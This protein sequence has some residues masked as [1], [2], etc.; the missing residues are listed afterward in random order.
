MI[1]FAA[2]VFKHA[3]KTTKLPRKLEV[4]LVMEMDKDDL[5]PALTQDVDATASFGK[6]LVR[7][8]LNNGHSWSA[9]S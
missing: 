4:C 7:G 5:R 8:D 9:V 2:N 3:F 6:V 1:D